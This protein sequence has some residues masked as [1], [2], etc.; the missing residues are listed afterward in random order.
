MLLLSLLF[1]TCLLIK[2]RKPTIGP[3]FSHNENENEKLFIY[4]TIGS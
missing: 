4:N 3:I 1:C 2:Q